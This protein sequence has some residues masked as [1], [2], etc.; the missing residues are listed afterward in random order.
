MR[1]TSRRL[2]SALSTFKPLLKGKNGSS[3]A[4]EWVSYLRGEL[5]WLADALGG[6]RDA[7]VVRDEITALLAGEPAE[8]VDPVAEARVGSSLQARHDTAFQKLLLTLSSERYLALL[9][10]LDLLVQADIWGKEGRRPA[11]E[12]LPGLLRRT[13]GRTVRCAV[14]AEAMGPAQDDYEPALHEVRKAAKRTRYAADA[15]VGVL[16]KP[17]RRFTRRLS[18]VQEC[19]GVLQDS[20][21]IRAELLALAEAAA[22]EGEPTFTYGRL[23]ALQQGAADRAI[24]AF[25]TAWAQA[26][27]AEQ[28]L[29]NC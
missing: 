13:F 1:V 4:R 23:H 17:V 9:D 19:L 29:P 8:L 22:A 15:V 28:E 2:R 27:G 21:V 18:V 26:E 6:P 7:E 11:V 12:V 25:A 14:H 16:G 20:V 10:D 24:A 3:T 5:A